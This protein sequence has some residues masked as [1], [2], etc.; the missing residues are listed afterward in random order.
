MSLRDNASPETIR[1]SFPALTLAQVYGAI[2]YY[3][4]HQSESE[5][6]LQR[7]DQKWKDLEAAGQSP[8]ASLQQRIEQ[9]RE[10]HR[11]NRADLQ[12]LSSQ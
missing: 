9:A 6:Y 5:A 3:L 8:D 12:R 10:S 2:A 4:D 7:L 1:D 11:S